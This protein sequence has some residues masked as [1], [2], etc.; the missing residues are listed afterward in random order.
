MDFFSKDLN[1]II[2]DHDFYMDQRFENR[3]RFTYAH[4][5]GHLILHKDEIQQCQFRTS[6]RMGTF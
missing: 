2:I 6:R 3:L 5:V 4:E 1:N